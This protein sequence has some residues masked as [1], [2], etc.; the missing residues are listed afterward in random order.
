MRKM[1]QTNHVFVYNWLISV[2]GNSIA[3]HES[4]VLSSVFLIDAWDLVNL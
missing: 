1:L 4:I 3:L 2:C